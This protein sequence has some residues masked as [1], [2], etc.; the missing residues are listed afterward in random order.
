MGE[1]KGYII[2][3]YQCVFDNIKILAPVSEFVLLEIAG[4][5]AKLYNCPMYIMELEDFQ[6]I[7]ISSVRVLTPEGR[8]YLSQK[9]FQECYEN[10]EER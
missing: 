7:R 3:P 6:T 1:V 8:L 10:K 5:F 9:S 4:H 2:S